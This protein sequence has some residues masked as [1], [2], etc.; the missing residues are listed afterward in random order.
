MMHASAGDG[1]FVGLI[2]FWICLL[3]DVSA[4]EFAPDRYFVGA[5]AP[6]AFVPCKASHSLSEP[7]RQI[8]R[9]LFSIHSSGFDAVEYYENARTAASKVP[10]ALPKTLIIAPQFFE[11]PA[12]PGPI[13]EG[14]LYWKVSPF[15]GSSR[16][17][18]GPEEKA[19]GISA[20][21]VLD[22]WLESLA[23]QE[24][25]PQLRDIVLV[26]H[27]GGGQLVQHYA[28]VGKF[29]PAGRIK[30]RYVVSA[31][32]SYAYPS[33]ERYHQ[34]SK[35]FV[36]PDAK[37]L[38]ACPDYNNWGYGLDSPYGYFSD[39][40][41]DAIAKRYAERWV[42]YLCG[43]NDNDPNDAAIG[44]SCG[45]MMQGR[46]RLERMQVFDAYLK[47]KYG[48]KISRRHRFAVVPKVGH[49]GRG[50]M[51]SESGLAFIF[52]PIDD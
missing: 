12:I 30:C 22:Q 39:T 18:I 17:A 23:D 9:I 36:V 51:T 1:L 37:T 48:E 15:R 41:A 24:R 46:H 29:E 6:Q 14:L 28:M 31:P 25:F 50:T 38:S 42:F 26:G 13:P 5:K 10:G 2:G 27:S 40:P 43:A 19:I 21:D 33:G 34:P 20:F 35:R 44:K 45:A 52:S 11:K 49:F 4:L 7:N 47:Q 8:T 16:G 32:S 3:A